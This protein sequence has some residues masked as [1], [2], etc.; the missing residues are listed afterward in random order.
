MATF[1]EVLPDLV[2]DK[3]LV[4]IFKDIKVLKVEFEK[5]MNLLIFKLESKIIVEFNDRNKMQEQIKYK[6]FSKDSI[7]IDLEINY[8]AIDKSIKDITAQYKDSII[9]QA[10]NE[11]LLVFLLLKNTEWEVDD[12]TIIIKSVDNPLASY[13]FKKIEKYL[14]KVYML[15]GKQ[16]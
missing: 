8:V 10:K 6:L 1:F 7:K 4:N 12:Y 16:D 2:V 14:K 15:F 5:K 3:K 11:N 9:N 13:Q